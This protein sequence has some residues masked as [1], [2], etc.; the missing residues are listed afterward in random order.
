VAIAPDGSFA[1]SV[2][3]AFTAP[4]SGAVVAVPAQ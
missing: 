2:N 3:T 4:G 1:V